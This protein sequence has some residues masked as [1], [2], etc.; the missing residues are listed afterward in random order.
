MKKVAFGAGWGGL[1]LAAVAIGG[2]IAVLYAT[3]VLGPRTAVA[4]ETAVSTPAPEPAAPESAAPESATDTAAAPQAAPAADEP[5]APQPPRF[6]TVRVEADGLTLIAGQGVAR[7]SIALLVNGQEASRIDTDGTGRFA[8]F[9][10]LPPSDAPRTLTMVMDPEGE[11]VAS[12]EEV[13]IAPTPVAVAAA[14]SGTGAGDD[15]QAADAGASAPAAGEPADTAAPVGDAT[16]EDAPDTAIA[17]TEVEGTPAP[18]APAPRVAETGG[19]GGSALEEEAIAALEPPAPETP[20]AGTDTVTASASSSETTAAPAPTASN[21]TTAAP[22]PSAST[23]T[24]AAPPAGPGTTAAPSATTGS[25]TAQAPAPAEGT[26]TA[27]AAGT[28]A[29]QAPAPA[30]STETAADDAADTPATAAPEV[31]QN[32]P[33]PS[34]SETVAA[35]PSAPATASDPGPAPAPTVIVSRPGGVDVLQAPQGPGGQPVAQSQLNIGAITYDAD[36]EVALSGRGGGTD[37]VRVYLDNR[38]VATVRIG[39]DGTWRTELPEVDTGT[40]TLRVDQ[41]DASG[42]VVARAESPFLRESPEA[43]AEAA[44]AVAGPLT[45]VTVQP[46]NT[47]WAIARDRYGEGIAYVRVFEAN[48][49]SIRDPDLIYPGQ[50]FTLPDE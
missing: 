23:E 10:D 31:A 14:P 40:Y 32:A 36:G 25:E 50:I 48:R 15:A 49:D 26:E 47:L 1:G 13:I 37:F 12:E 30:T 24:A 11:A 34:P 20:G 33:V 9:L 2:L 17:E 35:A 29:A 3:G 38:P 27:P 18:G 16:Q 5:T 19:Q 8:A 42:T 45:A 7:S 4:P 39:R 21:E 41:V 28:E 6:D 46:G 43:L 22:E 44:G